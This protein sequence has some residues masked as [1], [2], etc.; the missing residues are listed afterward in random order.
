MRDL[1][2][3]SVAV[4]RGDPADPHARP[5]VSLELVT[6]GRLGARATR[7]ALLPRDAHA[8]SDALLRAAAAVSDGAP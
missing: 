7:A 1:L 4:D 8:L 3:F 6:D 5:L 2:R